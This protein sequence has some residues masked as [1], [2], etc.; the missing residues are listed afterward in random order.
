M[1]VL[2]A[3]FE[4]QKNWNTTPCG[5]AG[6]DAALEP[7]TFPFFTEATRLRYVRDDPWVPGALE[8]ARW[9]GADTLEIGH[10]MGVDIVHMARA[11]ARV[12]AVDITQRHHDLAV[13]HL[14]L[15]GLSGDLR[16]SPA[17]NLPFET[18]KF[19]LVHSLGVLHHTADTVRCLG[20]AWR[21]LK[22]GGELRIALYNK[23]SL[24]HLYILLWRG[25]WQGKLAELG[26]DGLLSTIEFGAD[27]KTIKPLVK[28]Y[29]RSQLRHLLGDF[30]KVEIAVRGLAYDRIPVIGK[31]IPRPLGSLLERCFGW[32]VIARA[33]K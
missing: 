2:S 30:S 9:A 25:L 13:A 1:S 28:L 20:E 17:Q 11:G 29:T 19:D 24:F 16:L 12:H 21:V 7:G 23:W 10:G 22:P 6:L 18:E 8:F 32:Y 33:T 26:Y 4:A 27:G 5:T 14:A 3:N 31:L 15:H